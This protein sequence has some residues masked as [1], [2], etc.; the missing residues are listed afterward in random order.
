MAGVR[1]RVVSIRACRRVEPLTADT[2]VV[3]FEKA[4][5]MLQG[6]YPMIN[7]QFVQHACG[8]FDYVNREDDTGDEGLRK[9]KLSYYPEILLKKYSAAES[10]VV[11]ADRGADA[12][13][14][15]KLW[16]ACFDD[17]EADVAYYMEQRMTNENMLV[18]HAEGKIVS[19]ASFL[20]VQYRI[21]GAYTD[22]YYVYAVGTLPEY[23]GRGYATQI[24][25]VAKAW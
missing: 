18:I 13:A 8:A 17:T 7:Q 23:R 14:V 12:D 9:A 24:L 2:F 10:T 3:H 1:D 25:E 15:K 22:A 5:P 6:A 11:F 19:M 20:P 4:Y 21:D 16:T